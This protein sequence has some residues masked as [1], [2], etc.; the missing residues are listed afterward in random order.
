MKIYSIYDKK[1]LTYFPPFCVENKIQAIRGVEG[2]VNSS[3]NVLNSYPDDFALYFIA[4]F[5][6]KTGKIKQNE[7]NYLECEI[8]QLVRTER[9]APDLSG[10]MREGLADKGGEK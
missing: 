1:A 4:E 3:G 5:D 7:L 9:M 8:R 10:S 6:E 2:T